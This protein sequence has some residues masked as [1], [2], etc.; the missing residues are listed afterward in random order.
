MHPS[1]GAGVATLICAF[2]MTPSGVW[3]CARTLAPSAMSGW[4]FNLLYR[5][6]VPHFETPMIW[7]YGAHLC[8]CSQSRTWDVAP[9]QGARLHD[10]CMHRWMD[11]WAGMRHSARP[12]AA[13]AAAMTVH[14]GSWQLAGPDLSGMHGIAVLLRAAHIAPGLGHGPCHAMPCVCSWSHHITDVPLLPGYNGH[15]TKQTK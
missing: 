11:G 3:P 7:K 13:A 9:S 2:E 15:F 14:A 6:V 10:A 4:R 12:T 5:S 1:A 8:T